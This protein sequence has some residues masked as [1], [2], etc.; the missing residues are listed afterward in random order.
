MARSFLAMGKRILVSPL[1]LF[2]SELPPTPTFD[3]YYLNG[4]SSLCFKVA[5]NPEPRSDHFRYSGINA[6]VHWILG[7]NN[8]L[9]FLK[10]KRLHT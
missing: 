5:P 9:Q 1:L 3:N 4:F 7:R 2:L 8:H 6:R 10:A